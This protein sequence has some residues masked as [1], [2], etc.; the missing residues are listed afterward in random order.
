MSYK[1]LDNLKRM[2]CKDAHAIARNVYELGFS[3]GVSPYG[4]FA[5]L[6]VLEADLPG[7]REALNKSVV[8]LGLEGRYNADLE[9]VDR[10]AF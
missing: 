1:E 8:D 9:V 10:E 6:T 4:D 3:C 2:D 7:I 5:R